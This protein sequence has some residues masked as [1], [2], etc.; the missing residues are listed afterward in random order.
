MFPRSLSDRVETLI[1]DLI[2]EGGLD[3]A[4]LA[5]ILVAAQDSVRGG[6]CLELS[7]Q[8][9][10]V[11]NALKVPGLVPS[12]PGPGREAGS[13]AG[14]GTTDRRPIGGAATDGGFEETRGARCPECE[15]DSILT[16]P[17]GPD[18]E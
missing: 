16:A 9:W 8:V 15:T 11:S 7:R 5:S 13:G 6:Y 1:N 2:E 18:L 4:S 10:L 12:A 17:D 3:S 14:P